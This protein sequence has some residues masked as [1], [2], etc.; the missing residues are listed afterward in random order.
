MTFLSLKGRGV[1]EVI[2]LK[3]LKQKKTKTYAMSEFT[4]QAL[5]RI[6]QLTAY[7]TGLIR[8][9]NGREL[10]E[11]F[12]IPE[13]SFIPSDLLLLFDRLFGKGFEMEEIKEASSKLFNSLY[14][15]LQEY[16][17]I[18]PKD[19]SII[20][21][22]MDDNRLMLERM[23][24]TKALIKAL[25]QNPDG[26][27]R[28][29]LKERFEIFQVFTAHYVVKENILFPA[30]EQRWPNSSCLKLM[31]SIHDDIRRNIR[32]S[33]E[34]LED[35]SFDLE[36]FNRVSSKV[37]F[38]VGTIVFREERVLFPVMLESFNNS[39]LDDMLRQAAGL[40]LPFVEVPHFDESQQATSVT[41]SL[42]DL[43]T[44]LL[45]LEQLVLIFNHLPVD[46]TYV[47]E[48]DTVQFFSTPKHRIFPRTTGII[49]R[50][51]QNCHPHESVEVVNRIVESF[52][53]GTKDEASFWI[54]M[55][56]Q[57]V[58]IKYFAV[59]SSEGAYRGVLEVSQEITDIQQI[60][61]EKRLLDW[62][63]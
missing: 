13:T 9:E 57:F 55:R 54:N 52:R 62:E 23:H 63:A 5:R 40:G 11:H 51:V 34:L 18:Q 48:H 38:N 1:N 35:P 6:E 53:N 45:T 56:G 26:Q 17:A 8:H 10:L 19:G 46:L 4:Q 31:W 28:K 50:K 25:N 22:L 59:R 21:L 43:G 60:K 30:I 12:R 20:D 15:N 7:T 44:G 14:K 32:K 36:Q 2:E 49:G 27:V 33:I 37:Y 39:E 16:P 24:E 61:G 3:I 47:N 42:I 41:G 29:T 58:L